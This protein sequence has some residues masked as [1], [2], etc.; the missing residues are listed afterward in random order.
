MNKDYTVSD[1]VKL[2]FEKISLHFNN[3]YYSIRRFYH[4]HLFIYLFIELPGY[5]VLVLPGLHTKV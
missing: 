1:I 2:Y 4:L 3:Y 5:I